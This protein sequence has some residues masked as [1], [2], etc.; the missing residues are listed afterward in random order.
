MPKIVPPLTNKSIEAVPVPEKGQTPN[1][2]PDGNGLLIRVSW[3]GRRTFMH[4]YRRPLSSKRTTISIGEYPVISLKE[5]RDIHLQQRRLLQLKI[6][7]QDEQA[8]KSKLKQ[9]SEN[10]ALEVITRKWH[11]HHVRV[12]E[13]S[14][15]Y[16]QDVIRYFELHIFPKG[17][18]LPISELSAQTVKELLSPLES[19]GKL[20]AVRRICSYLNMVMKFAMNRQYINN[21]PIEHIALEFKKPKVTHQPALAYEQL[22]ELLATVEKTEVK[23]FVYLCFYLGLHTLVRPKN[24]AHA[25]WADFDLENRTWT[26]PAEDMKMGKEFYMPLTESVLALLNEV[27]ALYGAGE[28]LFPQ[29]GLPSSTKPMSSQ[30]VNAMLNRIGYSGIHTSHGN[31]SLGSTYINEMTDHPREYIESALAHSK[32]KVEKAYH[33]REYLE[34]RRPVMQDW[35]NYILKC[36]TKVMEKPSY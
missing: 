5:A 32:G 15:D 7:P 36:K 33:R 14:K 13:L 1:A 11:E 25:R 9:D 23:R 4:N 28:Y 20:E 27:K 26:I 3:T 22:P 2:K 19:V 29:S 35:S 30:S 31:R 17:G 10:H 12:K 6:D 18:T 8:N 24:A 16:A 21:N 34:K